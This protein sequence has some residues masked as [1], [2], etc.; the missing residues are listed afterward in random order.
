MVPRIRRGDYGLVQV[1][2]GQYAGRVG[3]YDGDEGPFAFVH[4]YG[5]YIS[6]YV[7]IR[8]SWLCPTRMISLELTQQQA[9]TEGEDQALEGE[10]L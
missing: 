7:L 9:C 2:E 1:V 10:S 6:Y 8:R 5:R 4:F 3:Y